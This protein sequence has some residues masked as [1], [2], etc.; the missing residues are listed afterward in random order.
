MQLLDK[1]QPNFNRNMLACTLCSYQG[2]GLGSRQNGHLQQYQSTAPETV[3][4]PPDCGDV[5]SRLAQGGKDESGEYKVEG[6]RK[7]ECT[8]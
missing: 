1:I 4:V 2:E 3:S 7:S 6:K 5:C 8:G